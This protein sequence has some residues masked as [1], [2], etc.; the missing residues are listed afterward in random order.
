MDR[1][2]VRFPGNR[3]AA[4][5]LQSRDRLDC[6]RAVAPVGG[7]GFLIP[8]AD[9]KLLKEIDFIPPGIR[10]DR[11][12]KSTFPKGNK[13]P[14]MQMGKI[15]KNTCRQFLRFLGERSL[16]YFSGVDREKKPVIICRN[17]KGIIN[18]DDNRC[19]LYKPFPLRFP[20]FRFDFSRVINPY[21]LS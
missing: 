12:I 18:T 4:G 2:V 19:F 17:I 14:V 8:R 13:L 1:T 6:C 10:K 20:C 3:K 7:A 16:C 11:F 15:R 21:F 9:Q 5:F